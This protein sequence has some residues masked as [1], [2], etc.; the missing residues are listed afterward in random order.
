MKTEERAALQRLLDYAGKGFCAVQ[1]DC[2]VLREFLAKA[3]ER[4]AA[5]MKAVA[6]QQPKKAK[7]KR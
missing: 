3:D 7:A 1:S 5:A 4:T 2:K 6:K